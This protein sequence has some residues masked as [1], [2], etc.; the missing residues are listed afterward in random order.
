MNDPFD[1]PATPVPRDGWG[2][3]LVVPLGGGKP[4]GYTRCTTFVDCMDDKYNLQR[5]E[6]RMVALGLASRPDLLLAVSAHAEDKNALNRI[7]ADAQE[8]AKAHAAATTGTALHALTEKIDRGEELPVIP[9]AYRADLDA[10]R[11]ATV[12]FEPLFIE[13]F[14]VLDSLKVG[15]T[16][17]CGLRYRGKAYIGD[18]KTGN[19]EHG[20][21]KIAMQL[22]VYSRSTPYDHESKTRRPYP[23]EIDQDWGIVIHLPAGTGTCELRWIDLASGWDAVQI[24]SR[25]REWR[26]RKDWYSPFKAEAATSA[27]IDAAVNAAASMDE[28]RAVYVRLVNEG[29]D[30]TV[31]LAACDK[32][33][34]EFEEAA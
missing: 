18:V 14:T 13:Q 34:G 17:D 22:A 29:N 2:R 10:Y 1:T 25:V 32:R 6:Q 15:G 16:P 27:A 8:A 31:V 3:P 21:M 5:W 28:L 20:A 33:R 7:T 9:E 11:R 19:I 12:E 30:P 26:K 24:A 4:V 23:E